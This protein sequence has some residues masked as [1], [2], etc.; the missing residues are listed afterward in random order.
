M[1]DEISSRTFHIYKITNR[2]NDKI[3]I[4]QTCNDVEA[5]WWSHKY[6]AL[7]RN[8]RT[9]FHEAIR[10]HGPDA[11]VV[12]VL[13]ECHSIDD[14]NILEE[15]LIL[16]HDAMNPDIGYNM[17]SGG[18]NVVGN[19]MSP[20]ACKKITDSKLGKPLTKRTDKTRE[21]DRPLVEAF[22]AGMTRHEIAEKFGVTECIV[23]KAL[24]RCKKRDKD[25]ELCVGQEHQYSQ[26]L[27]TYHKT[28]DERHKPITKLYDSYMRICD[29][30]RALNLN[31]GHVKQVVGRHRRR[32]L[33]T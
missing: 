9:R 12:E 27:L 8:G 10:K 3:Y 13:C 29:I 6:L 21:R 19:K 11:F 5:R 26:A 28:I 23:S 4:G 2:N 16:A 22:K 31:Y 32:K 30:A 20:D 15:K 14:A 24:H 33:L 18:A 7:Q 17:M 25:E 1:S